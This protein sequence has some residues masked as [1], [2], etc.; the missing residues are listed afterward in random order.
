MKK[1]MLILIA[2]ISTF[3]TT[4]FA[5]DRDWLENYDEAVKRA[6]KTGKYIFIDFS[7]SDWCGYCI[8]LENEVL[9]KSAFK[10]YA[11]KRLILLLVDFP[12]RKKQSA[13]LKAQNRKLAKRFG[14]Q[15]F[16]AVVI[17]TPDGKEIVGRSGFQTGGA[18][19]YVKDLDNIIN[20]YEQKK[21][22]KERVTWS[23]DYDAVR[24]EAIRNHKFILMDFT[25]SDS[26]RYCKELENQVFNKKEFFNYARDR[27]ILLS[28]DF[29]LYKKQSQQLKKQ[30]RALADKYTV[31]RFPTI[32][33]V[34][35]DGKNV[36]TR[37]G[38]EEGGVEKYLA[39]L[40]DFITAYMEDEK[41]DKK[42]VIVKPDKKMKTIKQ[43]EEE[44]KKKARKE[45]NKK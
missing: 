13:E 15:G 10:K 33:V 40:N 42:S 32:L 2:F 14:I 39:R 19:K 25:Q 8:R 22:Q 35:P 17:L 43:L 9:K 18:E 5:S 45:A 4:I 24:R 34:S 12:N 11:K 21:L 29:P 31:A 3:T 37:L 6:S 1:F 41:T 36:V 7:G 27:F 44:A 20:A 28:V 30:N 16:P 26:C 38:Y 23:N